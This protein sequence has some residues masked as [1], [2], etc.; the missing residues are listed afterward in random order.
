MGVQW[1]QPSEGATVTSYVIHYSNGTTNKSKKVTASMT[2]TIIT[3]LTIGPKYTVTV[4][5]T[6]NHLSGV[7]NNMAITLSK[8]INL[9]HI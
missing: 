6:S 7:S 9:W 2:N 5:A 4:E 3:N 1:S 8:A